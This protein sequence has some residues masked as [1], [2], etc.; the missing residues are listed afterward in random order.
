MKK[1][2]KI[3][4]LATDKAENSIVLS[5]NKLWY[6][7][8]YF[9]QEYLNAQDKKSFHLYI[10]S[11]DKIEEGDWFLQKAGRQFPIKW[12][13]KTK[14]NFHCKKIIA[15]TD[16]SLIIKHNC[17]CLATTFEGCSQCIERISQL[18]QQFIDYYI[19]EYNKGNII[20]EV[21]VEYEQIEDVLFKVYEQEPI[22]LFINKDN[23]INIS[24]P[25]NKMYSREEVE[26]LIIKFGDSY[27]YA[28]NKIGYLKWCDENL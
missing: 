24:I 12:D 13:G 22:K 23:T 4:M 19:T 7:K 14:L 26:K 11:D 9:T 25:S 21:E 16:K 3:V 28:S 20:T 6:F 5:K 18:S 17:D 8:G 2:H 27:S 15:T 10:L 1:L